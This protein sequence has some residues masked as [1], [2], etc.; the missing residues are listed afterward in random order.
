MAVLFLFAM[1]PIETRAEGSVSPA[2]DFVVEGDPSGYTYSDGALT[3]IAPGDYEV[4]MAEGKTVTTDKI[5]VTGGTATGPVNITLNGVFID[6]SSDDNACAFELK[7]SATVNLTLEGS[8]TLWSGA[9][10]AGLQVPEG[11][12]I[13]IYGSDDSSSLVA[14]S[15]NLGD[16]AGIGGGQGQTAGNITLYS[17]QINAESK[18]GAGIGGGLNGSG[19]T[20]I[21]HGGDITAISYLGS[22]IG[23]GM[24]DVYSQ[25]D[26]SGTIIIKGGE[27]NAISN[28]GGAGIGGGYYASGGNI[29]IDGGNITARTEAGGSGIGGGYYG[30]G[31]MITINGGTVDAISSAPNGGSGIGGGYRAAG[32]NITITSGKVTVNSLMSAIGDGPNNSESD[33]GLTVNISGGEV[34]VH[35]CPY[36]FHGYTDSSVHISGGTVSIDNC[37][38]AF[39]KVDVYVSGGT[40]NFSNELRDST[41]IITGG[42]VN[43]NSL[44]ISPTNGSLPL[45]LTRVNLENITTPTGIS[46]LSIGLDGAEYSY[47]TNDMKTDSDGWLYLYLP[48]NATVSAAKVGA[49]KY[50]GSVTTNSSG[51]ASGTLS[52]DTEKPT[53]ISVTLLD[54]SVP[55]SNSAAPISGQV[56]ITFSEEMRTD[57]GT[58][59][60][61]GNAV[62]GTWS[63][64]NTT[65][66]FDYSGLDY[67]TEHEI[68]ISGFMDY[69]GNVMEAEVTYPF[70]TV[71]SSDATL[72]SLDIGSGTLTPAFSS[73]EEN[74]TVSV[75]N[76]VDSLTVIPTA[77]SPYATIKV[78]NTDVASG[79][80][81]SIPISVGSNTITIVV[82]A[83][84]GGTKTYTITVNRASGGSPSSGDQSSGGS[85]SSSGTPANTATYTTST[86]N[87]VQCR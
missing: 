16:G 43:S 6:V 38:S 47:G 78:N 54:N 60:L 30:N 7:N 26:N 44:Q 9:Y 48:E 72:L 46:V 36:G 25:Y 34:F 11:T 29:T 66:T 63:N 3:F 20:I 59:T 71:Q 15:R 77:N 87:G 62:S 81:I 84:N 24:F 79:E 55:A 40:I 22:G 42:S 86:S 39:Y 31:G 52:L 76:S 49:M 28:D 8:N 10:F 69:S 12:S 35:S 61:G 67:D 53:V 83:Q 51:D 18:G 17:G 82:T 45:Y 56:R 2:G 57:N 21:I 74:Y 19:G 75:G 58:V 64:N 13:A 41:F 27:V 80:E 85:S 50:T 32:G 4:S 14:E 70:T 5:V 73:N 68:V 1:L 23:S 37:D 33:G 65:Y